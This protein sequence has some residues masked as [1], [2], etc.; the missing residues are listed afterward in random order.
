MKHSNPG[1]PVYVYDPETG[2][3]EDGF[4]GPGLLVMA[5]D[6]L[7]CE[8]PADASVHFGRAL[9]TFIPALAAADFDAG[10]DEAALPDPI[11]RAVILWR[12][13]F[14]PSFQHMKDFLA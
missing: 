7:P 13:E 1:N 11:R 2:R 3:A 8:L 4:D 5:V 12:G 10:L 9:L 6:N 14:A